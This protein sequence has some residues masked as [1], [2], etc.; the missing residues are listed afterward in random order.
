MIKP[1]YKTSFSSSSENLTLFRSSPSLV[2]NSGGSRGTSPTFVS[3]YDQLNVDHQ[4][5]QQHQQQ[6]QQQ[7][8]QQQQSQS[9]QQSQLVDFSHD[10]TSS[11]LTSPML[12]R[13]PGLVSN[14]AKNNSNSILNQQQRESRETQREQRDSGDNSPPLTSITLKQQTQQQQQQPPHSTIL[15]RLNFNVNFFFF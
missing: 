9:Q 12:I 3:K 4:Q 7:Q 2:L 13:R 6:S 11:P 5:Q 1:T 14:Y 10:A 8:S 15:S